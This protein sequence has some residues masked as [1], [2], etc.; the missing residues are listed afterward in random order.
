MILIIISLLTNW[1]KAY[2][3]GLEV[4]YIFSSQKCSHCFA[5][6]SG[7][8]KNVSNEITGALYFYSNFLSLQVLEMYSYLWLD[9]LYGVFWLIHCSSYFYIDRFISPCL[10]DLLFLRLVLKNPPL[11]FWE[12]NYFLNT[13]NTSLLT[14]GAWL[15]L[16]LDQLSDTSCRFSNSVGFRYCPPGATASNPSG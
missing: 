2:F 4:I 13:L 15:S 16:H 10:F 1:G 8:L 3:T 6:F 12:K 11:S 9:F 7:I 14:P 5:H